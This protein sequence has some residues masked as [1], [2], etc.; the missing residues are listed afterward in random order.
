MTAP[1]S[2]PYLLALSLLW[3]A[4]A[5]AQALKLATPF[6]DGAVLQREKPIPVWGTA[7]PGAEVRV[8][9]RQQ[10]MSAQSDAAGSWKAVLN[11]EIAG[12]PDVLTIEGGKDT[13][14]VKD[15]LVGEVWFASGQSNMAFQMKAQVPAWDFAGIPADPQFRVLRIG[16]VPADAPAAMAKGKWTSLGSDCSAVAWYFAREL[17]EKL[18]VPVGVITAS[19]SG[20]SIQS[21]I[22]GEGA[23]TVP[24]ARDE[25]LQ[26]WEKVKA[27]YPAL[28]AKFEAKHA[29]W[30]ARKTQAEAAGTPFTDKEPRGPTEPD[31]PKRPFCLYN[32]L[33]HP[34][35]PYAIRGFLWYQG[36]ADARTD[37]A[38]RYADLLRAMIKDW[39]GRWD[40][41]DLPFYIVQLPAFQQDMDW[42]KIRVAQQE[43][44]R[45]P[46][47]GLVVTLDTGEEKDVHPKNKE[48]VG[49]R[50][51][52]LALAEVYGQK[53]AAHFPEPETALR[54]GNAVKLHFTC[55]AG[56]TLTARPEEASGGLELAGA[57]GVFQPAQ[58]KREGNDLLVSSEAVPEP[59]QVRYGW[60]SWP[61]VSLYDSNGL[62]AGPFSLPV[63]AP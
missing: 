61:V 25:I 59:A 24:A 62:P 56:A 19:A 28:Q 51:A 58:A 57:D 44:A 17:R 32:G 48:P 43:V 35:A 30:Q 10:T 37:R 52:R 40:Q 42:V 4:S 16:I 54:V 1:R 27:D 8:K 47:N 21:W 12:G 26:A 5:A 60:A 46:G 15:V 11:P 23:D 49:Q 13:V 36:E 33:V 41:P 29:E 50:L 39:R 53:V 63:T 18:G 20:T 45:E 3:T 14:T 38:P 22:S 6:S 55:D 9:F 7:E 2:V 31:S 34:V